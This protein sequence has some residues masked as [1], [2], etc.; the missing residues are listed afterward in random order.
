MMATIRLQREDFDA[1]AETAA[2]LMRC[3]FSMQ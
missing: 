2:R 1:A 3:V